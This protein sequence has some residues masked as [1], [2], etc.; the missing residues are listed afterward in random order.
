M[1][2]SKACES[3]STRVNYTGSTIRVWLSCRIKVNAVYVTKHWIM[4][5]L[6]KHN[7][8]LGSYYFTFCLESIWKA[9]KGATDKHRCI[10]TMERIQSG[11]PI[12]PVDFYIDVIIRKICY[13][14]FA[15]TAAYCKY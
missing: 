3:Y 14:V 5:I 7:K 2:I 9:I 12:G 6:A 10:F 11:V 15:F 4:R 1:I 8:A 13:G